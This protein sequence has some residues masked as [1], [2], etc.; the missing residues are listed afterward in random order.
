MSKL[1]STLILSLLVSSTLLGQ[2][3]KLNQTEQQGL[4]VEKISA[5]HPVR[6]NTTALL[7]ILERAPLE[8][9]NE[10]GLQLALPLPDGTTATFAVYASPILEA[11]LSR[12]FPNFKSFTAQNIDQ[13]AMVGRLDW[14]SKGF[15]GFFLSPQGT[16]YLDPLVNDIYVSYYKK[17]RIPPTDRKH[18]CGMSFREDDFLDENLATSRGPSSVGENLR[19]LR[20][21]VATTGE[22]TNYHGNATDALAAVV[23][24]INRV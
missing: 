13:P 7:S 6:L 20:I 12:K 9:T 19:T 17:D 23:T 1:L 21:A 22:Y 2:W 4:P 18:F 10:A 24:T 14:T 16:I 3:T 8:F 11:D 15:H 5:Y